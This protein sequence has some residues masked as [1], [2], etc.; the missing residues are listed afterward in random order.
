MRI[1]L[2]FLATIC[3]VL[4]AEVPK[5][6]LLVDL[7]A[8]QGV[9]ADAQHRVTKWENQ[10]TTVPVREFSGQDKGRKVPGSGL[11]T[12]VTDGVFAS[13]AFRHQELLCRDEKTFDGLI[14]GSGCTW[15]TLLKVYP[16]EPGLKDVH[17]FFGNLRNGAKYEGL[18]GCVDDE[19]RI[20]WGARN[21]LTF[22]RFDVNN[23]KVTGPKL[24]PDRFYVVGG[25]LAA[26]KGNVAIELFVDDPKAVATGVFPVNAAADASM[27]AVGQE[28]DAIQHP[29]YESFD[30]EIARFLLWQRPLSDTELSTVITTLRAAL[31]SKK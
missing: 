1:F 14:Q 25:R 26:G 18:W 23:P 28:R 15:L 9:T 27:L 24:E 16:Q 7:D 12:L 3:G 5:E 6:G 4:A 2:S 8:H 31:P 21:G 29:G 19:N 30:G 20:W 17:S 11:P 13:V 10:V 22:G